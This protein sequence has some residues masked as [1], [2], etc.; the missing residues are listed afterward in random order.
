MTKPT[1]NP[2][3][4]LAKARQIAD[5]MDLVLEALA[6]HGPTFEID[7]ICTRCGQREIRH[8]RNPKAPAEM[9]GICN[10]CLDA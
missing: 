8:S 5:Y 1:F 6:S 10:R 4:E 2:A 7:V 3:H 9:L